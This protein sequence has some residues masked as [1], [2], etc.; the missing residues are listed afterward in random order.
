MDKF[1]IAVSCCFLAGCASSIP[2]KSYSP[3]DP[4]A[5]SIVNDLPKTAELLQRVEATACSSNLTSSAPKGAVLLAR[6]KKQAAQIGATG[7]YKMSYS[8][9]GLLQK[10]VI[11]PGRSA[12]GIAFRVGPQEPASRD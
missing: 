5:I 3:T 6:I 7:I 2:K 11:L 1:L 4:S 10:C 12:T 8:S 9:T